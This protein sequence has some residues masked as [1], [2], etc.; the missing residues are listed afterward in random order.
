MDTVDRRDAESR[1]RRAFHM[2]R[3]D[4]TRAVPRTEPSRTLVIALVVIAVGAHVLGWVGELL[5]AELVDRRPLLLAALNP[6]NRTLLLVTNEL[7]ALSFYTVAFVRLVVF[8][9]VYF[10]LGA[11]FGSRVGAWMTQ[12]SRWIRRRNETCGRW[13]RDLSYPLVFVA[14]SS[15]VSL[16]AGAV[17]M[18]FRT[19]LGLN[20]AGTAA[21]LWLVRT[22]GERLEVPLDTAVRV[23]ADHRALVLL[24]S[25]AVVGW[26]AHSELRRGAIHVVRSVVAGRSPD[27]PTSAE[28]QL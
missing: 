22:I 21:R 2:Y 5:L 12:R 24:V 11:W 18:R 16:V 4:V 13:V 10:V 26:L 14:P 6:T 25:A 8:D 1:P 23:I 28:P 17:G 9:P 3:R 20:V 27:P 15:Y 19:F 7:D